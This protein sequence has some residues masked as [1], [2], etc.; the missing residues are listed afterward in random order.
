VPKITEE[1]NTINS[2]SI[3]NLNLNINS[4]LEKAQ[5]ISEINIQ[6][7]P[8]KYNQKIIKDTSS[9]I[10]P[11]EL[12]YKTSH[13]IDFI[14]Q[15]RSDDFKK[16]VENWRNNNKNSRP[17]TSRLTMS[18]KLTSEIGINI[19]NPVK[20]KVMSYCWNCYKKF[21]KEE[22]VSKEYLNNFKLN[23]KY[24][25]KNFCSLK[26]NKDYEKKQRSQFMCFQCKKISNIM[27]GFI[28]FEGNKFCSNICKN[29]YIE[30]EK[31]LLKNQKKKNK[32]NKNKKE[33]NEYKEENNI[34]EN[35]MDE[36][37]IKE[38]DEYDPFD[39]F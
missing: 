28:A 2:S 34:E 14:E 5:K 22:G 4:I 26:C 8:Q 39:D 7:S 9:K 21:V 11:E 32:K 29:K 27:D 37:D 13:D 1:K 18:N 31:E 15:K 6:T 10:S 17:N 16:A 25:M 35:D 20:E 19:N 30:E 23:E 38:G 36:K 24:N 33:N 3:N 12:M